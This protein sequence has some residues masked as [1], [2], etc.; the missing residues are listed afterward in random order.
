MGS[1][2][3]NKLTLKEESGRKLS[4]FELQRLSPEAFRKKTKLPVVIVLD[5][6]R[7]LHNIGSVFRTSDAFAVQKIFLCGITAQPPH[8]EIQ[9]TALGATE[10]VEW[11]YASSCFDLV[12]ELKSTGSYI[13]GVEQVKGST[14][15]SDVQI[16]T[17]SK[18]VLVFGNE[19]E[20]VSQ[21]VLDE[22]DAFIEIPQLGSKHSLNV[23]VS[24]G[25]VV[26][27]FLRKF[28]A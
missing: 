20:G 2:N 28:R 24:V 8:R 27:E 26:W 11:E 22:C 12:K 7:S 1:S 17:A 16:D 9:K 3:P 25:I 5:D 23:S 18:Y 6:I 13:F 19:V 10:T 15:L 14:S 21:Q 4:T